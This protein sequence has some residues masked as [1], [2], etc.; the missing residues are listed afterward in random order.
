MALSLST[1]FP[2]GLNG[3]NNGCLPT[4]LFQEENDQKNMKI[5]NIKNATQREGSGGF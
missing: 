1:H 5:L 4:C 2:H 3:D